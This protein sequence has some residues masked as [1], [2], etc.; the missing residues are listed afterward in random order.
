MAWLKNDCGSGPETLK[1]HGARCFQGLEP[2]SSPILEGPSYPGKVT[3]GMGLEAWRAGALGKK[4]VQ[5]Q[6]STLPQDEDRSSSKTPTPRL[7]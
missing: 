2:Q 5:D 1:R 7:Y 3:E 4:G 6:E